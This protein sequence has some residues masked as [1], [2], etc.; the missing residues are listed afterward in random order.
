[1]SQRTGRTRVHQL[2]HAILCVTLLVQ[3]SPLPL[4]A[5]DPGFGT[6][7]PAQKSTTSPDVPM[8]PG[9]SFV[10]APPAEREGKQAALAAPA[11]ATAATIPL[12]SGWN[13]ISLP[14][15]PTDTTP[16]AVLASIA[17][18][19]GVVYAYDN[20]DPADPWK[21]YDPAGPPAL[22]DLSRLDEKVGFWVQMTAPAS[23]AVAGRE[24]VSTTVQLCEG[25]NLV[26]FP[27]AEA[28]MVHRALASIAGRYTR[29]YHFDATDAAD[30]W[31]LYDV[32]LPAWVN[33]LQTMAPGRG[34]WI[35]ATQEARL[36]FSRSADITLPTVSVGAAPAIVTPGEAV[37]LAVQASDDR[38]VVTTTL[39]VNGAPVALDGNGQASFTPAAP[40]LYTARAEAWDA[41]GNQGSA[42][43][44]FRAR[45]ATDNG[46]PTVALTQ[47]LTD[48]IIETPTIV[49]GIA[50]DSDLAFYELQVAP[51]GSSSY[52]TFH[53]GT[54]AVTG[55]ALGRLHPGAF[56]PGLYTLRL[57]AE[58]TWGNRTCTPP[59]PVELTSTVP[60]PGFARFGFS[61]GAM[62][63]LGIPV[64][65]RRL[66]D[67]RNKRSG[68]FG[69][70]WNLEA[71]EVRV[72]SLGVMGADWEI[73]RE[74]H[75][76]FPIFALRPT[77]DHR[78]I[79]SL[80][81]GS[82]HRF[83]MGVSPDQSFGQPLQ[84]IDGVSFDP[85]PGTTS[86]LIVTSQ[87]TV[88]DPVRTET[89]PVTLRYFDN[90]NNSLLYDPGTFVLQL[91][92]GRQFGFVRQTPGSTRYRLQ[93]INDR[94][95]NSVHFG[96][97]GII[98]GSGQGI[99][100]TRDGQGRITQ[101]THPDGRTRSY[102]Y[103]TAGDLVATTDYEGYTTR[104]RYD[105]NHN[106][107]QIIDARGNV[108]GTLVYD[109]T[110][111]VVGV[112][113]AN[114]NEVTLVHDEAN[115]R[116]IVTDRLGRTTITTYDG[117]G[118]VTAVTNPLLETTR[119]QY[120]ANDRL[121]AVTDP[122]SNTSR[123][124]YDSNGN[125]L[126]YTNALNESWTY[127]YNAHGQRL[128]ETDP[129]SRTTHFAYDSSGNPTSVTYPS[130][131]L[132]RFSYGAG[133]RMEAL[134]FAS[135][136]VLDLNY[137]PDGQ[138]N[139]YI[140]PLGRAS[141]LI[142]NPDGNLLAEEFVFEGQTVR[143][144]YEYDNNGALKSMTYPNGT[145]STMVVDAGGIPVAA[146]NTR[147]DSQRM[148]HDIQN[149]V[150]TLTDVDGTL[151]T[152]ARDLE[153]EMVGME[154]G[155]EPIVTRTL[156]ALSRPTW[157][158]MADGSVVTATYDA[159]GRMTKTG[160]TGT[161]VMRYEYDAAGRVVRT[162][163]PDGGVTDYEYDAAGQPSAVVNPLRERTEFFYD[164]D[165]NLIQTL[166]PDGH[167]S[168][169]DY[170]AVG[171]ATAVMDER[172]T[173][174]AFG[175]DLA[176]QL[177]VLTDTAGNPTTFAYDIM[178]NVVTATMPSGTKW[179]Y[180]YNTMGQPLT[181]TFPWGGTETIHRDASGTITGLT[182]ATGQTTS[183]QYGAAGRMVQRTIHGSPPEQASYTARGELRTV[184]T[185]AGA[186]QYHYDGRGRLDR[187]DNP[188]GSWV[189]YDYDNAGRLQM[190][191]TANGTTTYQYDG[192]GR[193]EVVADSTV[194]NTRYH[195]DLAGRVERVEMAD[196]S[197][198]T[199]TRSAR[200][201]LTRIRTVAAD[202]IT[203][204][205]DDNIARDAAGNTLQVSGIG[206][207]VDYGYDRAGRVV[208]ETRNGP[209]AALLAYA[210]DADWNLTQIGSRALSYDGTTRLTSD[211]IWT[212][213]Q[214]DAAGRP[215]SRSNGVVTEEF[216]YDSLNRLTRVQRT[217][218]LPALVTL[219]Y[220]HAD[221]L[222]RIVAD[223]VGRRLVWDVSAEVPALLEERSD[224]GTLMRRYVHGLGPVAVADGGSARI[225][226]LD[227]LGSVSVVT[228]SDGSVA[229]RYAFA[230]YGEQ[231]LG[232][233]DSSTALRFAGEYFVPE[234]NLYFLRARFYDP[235]AGRF[236][237]PDPMD[238]EPAI[239]QS[240]NPYLYAAANPVRYTD[241]LGTFSLGQ[242]S[243]GLSIASILAS[244]ALPHFEGPAK[245]LARRLGWDPKYASVPVGISYAFS[246]AKGIAQGGAQIDGVW[247]RGPQVLLIGWIF[248]G[249]TF[250]STPGNPK[251]GGR[252]G[253]PT[254]QQWGQVIMGTLGDGS[255]IPDPKL[256]A[257]V[258]FGGTLAH[259]ILS[260]PGRG[261]GGGH[262]AMHNT[263]RRF[264]Y[265]VQ[266]ELGS[267]NRD[268]HRP[269]RA[270][271]FFQSYSIA[272]AEFPNGLLVTGGKVTPKTL[273]RTDFAAGIT[274]SIYAP[275]AWYRIG[276]SKTG[277]F[278][279]FNYW[280]LIRAGG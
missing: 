109:G 265:G 170:D 221:L 26:G 150:S 154:I 77:R 6:A 164:L 45:S 38:G 152:V 225:L 16:S 247:A 174:L 28:Q 206:R 59:R 60:Q 259:M 84:T 30:P 251:W 258:Q 198:T 86:T 102:A 191:R 149:Q 192:A 160:H 222:S 178:G 199:Y 48:T 21:R 244:L 14:E 209:D 18:D 73:R 51:V 136:G 245:W 220:N 71:A 63:T 189:E 185:A 127:S 69:V 171:R 271:S 123:F 111:R 182:G 129:L 19:H 232:S 92:D 70:G 155:G 172:G 49:T 32:M 223:G 2:I 131:R 190:L 97:D 260:M 267:F 118:N 143:Y 148:T 65:V 44:L 277:L 82:V 268:A 272:G 4:L 138:M 197:T 52:I 122:L 3:A 24:A 56:Q 12:V 250:G 39:T 156:D 117:R 181:Q 276:M 236:L 54:S 279:G 186:T 217:G 180:S 88:I 134:T 264:G 93:Q 214:Y 252:W 137:A 61:D 194:G 99:G 15:V 108:P 242:I 76:A 10:P 47:P 227:A 196:G 37:A 184:T 43:A 235:V 31:K 116:E 1:M 229:S 239:P 29:V 132:E 46:A 9:W 133:G 158:A 261:V 146:T 79:V 210:Y 168:R 53:R 35:F 98:H 162:I 8:P 249:M 115:N 25:W 85:L 166:H 140:D 270:S 103:D 216:S 179:L 161:G 188:D 13:L 169:I 280:Q 274:L 203:V 80:P 121:I 142:M 130:G 74:G 101:I 124:G 106:L 41:A 153:G 78:V 151:T 207:Q 66:Y 175:Y 159:A 278:N 240:Y 157:M 173:R 255:R 234:L 120:D 34:Y 145:S 58:D 238:P 95:G 91:L 176:G 128:T 208:T 254:I 243:L 113:D 125:V 256:G 96:P 57:C 195:Y 165:G 17:G 7:P 231:T 226:H 67:S 87:P 5:A 50:S 183:Y 110:G 219:E 167:T 241:P 163:A 262:N 42:T 237:T 218:A 193:L 107:I 72:E 126:T 23:L 64:T 187:I 33:D 119:Y 141:T 228:T 224:S 62:N 253:Q 68:D 204:I 144:E 230:A 201:W 200:G 105:G 100:F 94:N 269:E 248:L 202:G 215:T 104:Y 273:R 213:Y 90:A 266:W 112:I 11:G 233:T 83:R 212:S 81:D 89:G 257:Y 75:P 40:G 177:A 211:G 36:T 275:I 114:G 246:G 139:G 20:C 205:R 55:G 147:G 27:L 135:G 22:N 263:F